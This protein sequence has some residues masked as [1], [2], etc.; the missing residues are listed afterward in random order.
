MTVISDHLGE[1]SLRSHRPCRIQPASA[2]TG[3]SPAQPYPVS[4]SGGVLCLAWPTLAAQL[5][6]W[7]SASW[8]SM[9]TLKLAVSMNQGTCGPYPDCSMP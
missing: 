8:I 2:Y 9:T 6:A 5:V 3:G 4:V 7:V 1:G